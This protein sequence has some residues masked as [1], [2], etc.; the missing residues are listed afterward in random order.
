MMVHEGTA[1]SDRLTWITETH[2]EPFSD[3]IGWPGGCIVTPGWP[4][5]SIATSSATCLSVRM[6]LGARIGF[7]P[8]LVASQPYVTAPE[9]RLLTGRD[10][11]GPAWINAHADAL[12]GHPPPRPTPGARTIE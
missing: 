2:I 8:G 3:A 7:D 11:R 5:R 6:L 9:V 4:L 12:V 10:P 1:A